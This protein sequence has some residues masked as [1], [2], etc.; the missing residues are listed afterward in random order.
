MAS[1]R[2]YNENLQPVSTPNS[3][4]GLKNSIFFRERKSRKI[5]LQH[6]A[7]EKGMGF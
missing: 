4:M 6:V 5:V 3:C 2:Y 1:K 7:L